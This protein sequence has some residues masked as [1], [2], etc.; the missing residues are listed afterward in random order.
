MKRG[1][2]ASS[3]DLLHAGHVYTLRECSRK[4][5]FLIVG[6]HVGGRN[7]KLVETVFERWMRLNACLYVDEIVPYE[8]EEDLE[9]ILFTSDL[10]VRYLGEDYYKRNDI[11]GEDIVPI[12][13][14]PR[15]HNWSSTELKK[16]L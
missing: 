1:F 5:D 10:D 4:C 14:I 16:R 15:E 9:N 12:E 11:T 2:I 13:Y 6:L 3:W 7:K 8:T